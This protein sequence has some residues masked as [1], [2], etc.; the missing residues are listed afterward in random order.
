M[1]KGILNP[2]SKERVCF[3][4][5]IKKQEINHGCSGNLIQKERIGAFC[6]ESHEERIGFGVETE[7]CASMKLAQMY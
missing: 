3:Q 1:Q 5:Y 6:L 4:G 7:K 2:P